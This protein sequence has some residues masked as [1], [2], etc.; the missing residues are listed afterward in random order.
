MQQFMIKVNYEDMASGLVAIEVPDD[1][2]LT[3]IL[4]EMTHLNHLLYALK[5]IDYYDSLEDC[6]ESNIMAE[7]IERCKEMATILFPTEDD[8][9]DIYSNE[10]AHSATLMYHLFD[11]HKDWYYAKVAM[12]EFNFD[13]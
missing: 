10:G 2:T 5:E 4:S 13:D 9:E 7:E 1:V 11:I 12:T 3:Y 8:V 6:I